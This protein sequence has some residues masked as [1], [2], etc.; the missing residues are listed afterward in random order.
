M[1]GDTGALVPLGTGDDLPDPTEL[2]RQLTEQLTEHVRRIREERG[3]VTQPADTYDLVR[4]LTAV[5]ERLGDYSRAFTGV[6]DSAKGCLEEELFEAVSEQDGIP[7]A[8]LNVP[9]AGGDIT[10]RADTSN[11]HDIDMSQILACLAAMVADEWV[12]TFHTDPERG[13][14]A[15]PR[16]E[17]E[18]FAI[19]V[20]ERA[21]DFVGA[22]KPKVSK[23]RAFASKL[24]RA[25][26][27]D[28]S[29]VASSAIVTRRVYNGIKVERKAG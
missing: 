29:A 25:G 21:L 12:Q 4:R 23:V 24:A 3:P 8:P 28:L 22:A 1:T 6:A 14:L 27:D 5:R 20:A 15:M 2:K 17:P 16:D 18:Q 26:R 19:E 13:G 9:T 7:T 10:V 11:A